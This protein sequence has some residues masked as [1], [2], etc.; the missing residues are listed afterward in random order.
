[1]MLTLISAC[2]SWHLQASIHVLPDYSARLFKFISGNHW[3][4]HRL[5][6]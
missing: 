1:M 6:E 4:S 5:G 2:L 3:I